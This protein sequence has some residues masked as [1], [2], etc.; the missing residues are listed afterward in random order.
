MKL[1]QDAITSLFPGLSEIPDLKKISIAITNNSSTDQTIN[2]LETLLN[3]SIQ[4]QY[5]PLNNLTDLS[6]DGGNRAVYSQNQQAV[7]T[8]NPSTSSCEVYNKD[9]DVVASIA[10][11]AVP[12][13]ISISDE[14]NRVF[15]TTNSSSF[16]VI[17]TSTNTI[18]TTT[19]TGSFSTAGTTNKGADTIALALNGAS[20]M[21]I[22]EI[23]ASTLTVLNT[24]VI[25][26]G[27]ISL[28]AWN[29]LY[30]LYYVK[31]STNSL[32]TFDPATT[33][34]TVLATVSGT[35]SDIKY[36]TSF[37]TIAVSEIGGNRD[38][39]FYNNTGLVQTISFAS[40]FNPR[41]ITENTD[42]EELLINDSATSQLA[43]IT[44]QSAS[45]GTVSEYITTSSNN[46]GS[47]YFN[48]NS[49]YIIFNSA[50][51]TITLLD[52]RNTISFTMNGSE[53][54]YNYLL[55]DIMFNPILCYLIY[56]RCSD[57]AQI[58]NSMNLEI[59]QAT[60]Q[61]FIDS[62]Y[63][64]AFLDINQTF[65]NIVMVPMNFVFDGSDFISNYVLNAGVTISMILYVRQFKRS[66]MMEPAWLER[67][68]FGAYLQ[69]LNE[70]SAIFDE[71]QSSP[72]L[73]SVERSPV[74]LLDGE[75]N[76]QLAEEEY[77]GFDGS[78]PYRRSVSW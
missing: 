36:L 15:I 16:I 3:Q 47:S 75:D 34:L 50:S 26:T 54:K 6:R 61:T 38:L 48:D 51:T 68:N 41:Y 29:P 18:V 14:N 42:R 52:R 40:T 72:V 76:N 11:G 70:K 22:R 35:I 5:T 45:T 19:S 25:G 46:I 30:S 69:L 44:Q 13:D 9:G 65:D 74:E 63:P 17:D 21:I 55:N 58:S 8:F 43:F 53:A 78:V 64:D 37:Q 23:D 56:M 27:T 24:Y 10:L 77:L 28:I 32:E 62:K 67:N 66:R 71:Q 60:G 1:G 31:N 39:Y 59:S 57:A 20:N 2:I 7:Y 73:P 49:V 12:N 4:E 33:T